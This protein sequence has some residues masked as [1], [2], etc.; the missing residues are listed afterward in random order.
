MEYAKVRTDCVF[1][2]SCVN[3]VKSVS[4]S[5]FALLTVAEKDSQSPAGELVCAVMSFSFNQACT[6]WTV[7]SFG[8]TKAST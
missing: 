7:S 1:V 6:A 8:A 5:S 4:S 3:T 2:L